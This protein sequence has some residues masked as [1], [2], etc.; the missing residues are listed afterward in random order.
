M[1]KNKAL[2]IRKRVPERYRLAT[3]RAGGIGAYYRAIECY[4]PQEVAMF[5]FHANMHNQGLFSFLIL[6]IGSYWRIFKSILKKDSEIYVLNT[7]LDRLGIV[8][9]GVLAVVLTIT[10]RKFIVF[11]HGWHPSAER[12]IDRFGLLRRLFRKTFCAGDH[13]I[14]LSEEYEQKLRTWGYEKGV[15]CETTAVDD[16][17]L[18]GFD[19]EQRSFD[20][21]R[22][23]HVFYIGNII[24]DKGVFEIL[25]A[26]RVV[27]K[28]GEPRVRFTIAGDGVKLHELK[29]RAQDGRLDIDFPGYT[30]GSAKRRLF[31]KAD[32]F[33]FPSYH[34][35]MPTVVLEAMAFG[36][37]VLT[38]RVG[39]VPGFFEEGKMG[40]F[41]KM[42]SGKDIAEKIE[43]LS[44]DRELM[45]AM[46]KYN[47]EYARR[48]F[49]AS[50]V[51][52]RLVGIIEDVGSNGYVGKFSVSG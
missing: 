39:G 23:L 8:R 37:P 14:V 29:R 28:K 44:R 5:D 24:T 41:I 45:N 38:T 10:G 18:E 21:E 2:I 47:C 4:L 17:L 6:L 9:D 35:G 1:R 26:C 32:L 15:S 46:S 40:Y 16:A 20:C 48:R 25:D 31:E 36:L 12:Q 22:P 30:V 33:V 7:S 42:H 50:V 27:A 43:M 19:P 52:Q 51:A 3:H 13:I 11:F 34:E 49:Y